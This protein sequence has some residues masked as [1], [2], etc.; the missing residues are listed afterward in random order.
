MLTRNWTPAELGEIERRS[1]MKF[2]SSNICDF[3]PFIE[4]FEILSGKNWQ[5]FYAGTGVAKKDLRSADDN[6]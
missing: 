6:M 2:Y 4:H 3:S 1:W 5:Q